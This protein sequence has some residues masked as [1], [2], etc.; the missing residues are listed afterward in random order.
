MLR[1]IRNEAELRK[2]VKETVDTSVA[3]ALQNSVKALVEG[4]APVDTEIKLRQR[5]K[6]LEQRENELVKQNEKLEIEKERKEEAFTRQEREITH[7]I[8][9]EKTRMEQEREL[10]IREAKVIV[11]ESN[12]TE[13]KKRF[14]EQMEF[15]TKRFEEE[16]TYLH[17]FVEQV[18][19]RL[20]HVKVDQLLTYG[21]REE[22][23]EKEAKEKVG[24][25]A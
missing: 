11:K 9:L 8:G 14:D 13:E 3:A 23:K 25:D 17:T 12:L 1:R 15:M 10:A 24:A 22:K 6:V 18:L 21:Q 5:I 16:T 19:Q 20:P 2:A 4:F 7:K